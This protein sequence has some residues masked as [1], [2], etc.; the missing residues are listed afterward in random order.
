MTDKK[1]VLIV[2]DGAAYQR[3]L[4]DKL[5]SVGLETVS[6]ANGQE[7]LAV[8]LATHPDLI[9]LDLQMPKMGGIEMLK[10]L[11]ADEWGAEVS[12]VV[13]TAFADPAYLAEV[14]EQGSY[15]YF[16]KTDVTIEDL[17]EKIKEK[18]GVV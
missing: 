10:Q 2:E 7:G 17:V 18:L 16:V 14:M 3:A 6:A 8:A 1:T 12:V 13:L 11:R 4:A 15:D 5:G 9:V